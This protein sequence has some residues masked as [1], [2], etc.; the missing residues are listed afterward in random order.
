M[1]VFG[2]MRKLLVVVVVVVVVVLGMEC[3]FTDGVTGS[4]LVDPRG[5]GRESV[6]DMIY[7]EEENKKQ[8]EQIGLG[9]PSLCVRVSLTLSCQR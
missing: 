6:V 5:G 2:V 1:E 3:D 9:L 8:S 4:G 7:W